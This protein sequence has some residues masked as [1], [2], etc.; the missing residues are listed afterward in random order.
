MPA[1]LIPAFQWWI[2]TNRQSDVGP[3]YC[4]PGTSPGMTSAFERRSLHADDAGA[5]RKDAHVGAPHTDMPPLTDPVGTGALV[6]AGT[7]VIDRAAAGAHRDRLAL[8]PYAD[9]RQ[10]R[11]MRQRAAEAARHICLDIGSGKR[12][13]AGHQQTRQNQP[14]KCPAHVAPPRASPARAFAPLES[15]PSRAA[16]QAPE[17]SVIARLDP[18]AARSVTSDGVQFG[19]FG[20][21]RAGQSSNP[22]LQQSPRAAITGFPLSRK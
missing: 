16:D 17:C 6:G 9:R 5:A 15:A 19:S 4:M 14:C 7:A 21:R 2:S 12:P 1:G 22:A 8:L 20:G 11:L 10:E 3:L 18:P 13:E